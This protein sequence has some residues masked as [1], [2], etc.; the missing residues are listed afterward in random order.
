MITIG[1]DPGINIKAPGGISIIHEDISVMGWICPRDAI[2]IY[3]IL[4]PYKGLAVAAIEQVGIR[5]SDLMVKGKVF[6][7][8]K[9]LRHQQTC[10]A[11]C[12]VLEIPVVL[13]APM[14][15]KANYKLVGTDV[16]DCVA[17]AV[18]EFPQA[19]DYIYQRSPGGRK[20][21]P[22]SGIAAA[23][24]MAGWLRDQ[25]NESLQILDDKKAASQAKTKAKNNAK[26]AARKAERKAVLA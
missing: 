26:T 11:V 2:G 16:G 12:E 10:I 20:I 19:I 15:W 22:Y 4:E 7:I 6:N 21:V 17:K 23:L 9:M 3:R 25:T 13:I 8:E 1:I 14:K 18:T 24:L 5:H